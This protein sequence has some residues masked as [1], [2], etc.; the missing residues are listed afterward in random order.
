[1]EYT[2]EPSP[3][4]DDLSPEDN[5]SAVKTLH[6]LQTLVEQHGKPISIVLFYARYCPYSKRT[7]PGLRQWARSNKERI[8]LYEVDVEQAS[9]LAEYYHVRTV[10]TIMAFEG[11]NLLAPIWQR[12]ANNVL[13]ATSEPEPMETNTENLTDHH[14]LIEEVFRE[15]LDNSNNVFIILDP[16]S[17]GSNRVLQMIETPNENKQEQYLLLLDTNRSVTHQSKL[18]LAVTGNR[19]RG[20]KIAASGFF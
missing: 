14:Q 10:P 19:N 3:W 8:D 7:A 11:S 16:S 17:K 1:M 20:P 12:T 18:I 2:T 4:D 15:K 5:I 9:K 6:E 13:E